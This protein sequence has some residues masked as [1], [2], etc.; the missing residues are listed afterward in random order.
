M[1]LRKQFRPNSSSASVISDSRAE[2]LV[3]LQGLDSGGRAKLLSNVEEGKGLPVQVPPMW[4]G[5]TEDIDRTISMVQK[6]LGDLQKL[7]ASMFLPQVEEDARDEAQ[8]VEITTAEITRLL[9]DAQRRVRQLDASA[10]SQGGEEINV[11]VNLQKAYAGQLGALTKS[12]R[13]AQQLYLTT[14]RKKSEKFKDSFGGPTGMQ[15]EEF[16]DYEDKGFTDAQMQKLDRAENIVAQRDKQIRK[17]NK[18]FIELSDLVLVVMEH[19]CHQQ[20][21]NSSLDFQLK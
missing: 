6:K 13:T 2:K 19:S 10:S 9:T 8:A 1:S 14:L 3:E 5:A 21:S 12:F 17:I 18:S 11:L 7:H 20:E 4:V 16:D 15:E